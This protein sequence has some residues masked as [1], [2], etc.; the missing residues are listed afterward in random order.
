M[1]QRVSMAY[2]RVSLA[3]V[4]SVRRLLYPHRGAHSGQTYLHIRGD[5]MTFLLGRVFLGF[6]L[7]S[8]GWGNNLESVLKPGS[9]HVP[10][11]LWPLF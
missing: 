7:G 9:G 1:H 11:L 6:F 3:S 4:Q 2:S 5:G 8:Q 10:P